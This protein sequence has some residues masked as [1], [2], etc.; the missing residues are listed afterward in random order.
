MR[1]HGAAEYATAISTC[2]ATATPAAAAPWSAQTCSRLR[3]ALVARFLRARRGPPRLFARASLVLP[4][5]HVLSTRFFPLPFLLHRPSATPARPSGRAAAQGRVNSEPGSRVSGGFTKVHRLIM[6]SFLSQTPR[7]VAQV[8][9]KSG[10]NFTKTTCQR[11]RR[12]PS[13]VTSASIGLAN[14]D[15]VVLQIPTASP[16]RARLTH[17]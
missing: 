3:A 14:G 11:Y 16:H 6:S 1:W 15:V 12:W 17:E 2:S 4:R 10:K 5:A 9:E 7:P 8:R 13:D